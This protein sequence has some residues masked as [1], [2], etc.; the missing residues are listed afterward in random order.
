M[1]EHPHSLSENTHSPEESPQ[2]SAISSARSAAIL[3]TVVRQAV[4]STGM[5]AL[6]T[7]AALPVGIVS[8]IVTVQ[9]LTPT[10]FGR[11]GL[12][13]VLASF[14][15]VLYNVGLLHGT[16]LWV[17]GSSGEGGDDLEIEGLERVSVA[18]QKSAMGAG[19]ILTVIV[20]SCGTAIC[21]LFA[22]PLAATLLGSSR[23]AN[24]VGLAALSGG[25]GSIYRLTCNIFRFERRYTTY[26]L[27]TVARP[28]LVLVGS[29]GLV[30]AGYGIWGAVIGTTIPTL[31]CAAG[32]ILAAHRSYAFRLA[33]EDVRQIIR[34]GATVVIPVVALFGLHNGDLYLLAH[35]V[36]GSRLGVYRLA[37]RLGSPPSYFASAFV[38]TWG[39]LERSSLVTA[40]VDIAGRAKLRA[41]VL[42][43]YILAGLSIVVLFVLFSGLFVL[44]A[45]R[46]YADAAKV[47]PLIA[48]AFVMYGLYLMLLRTARPER[49]LIWY[50]TTAV[51]SAIVFV[52][53]AF[54]LIPALGIDGAPL[55]LV[56]GMSAGCAVVL[57]LNTRKEDPTPI[58]YRRILAGVATAAAVSA[59]ALAGS[60]EGRIVAA[61]C[62]LIGLVLYVPGLVL[63]RAIP[64]GDLRVL[65][66]MVSRRGMREPVHIS[67]D[68]LPLAERQA[69]AQFWA[70]TLEGTDNTLDY[71]RLTRALRRMARIGQP[72]ALDGPIGAYLASREPESARDYQMEDLISQ[73]VDAYE[74]YR[75]DRLAKMLRRR[76]LRHKP[77]TPRS[78]R[79]GVRS[80]LRELEE[81]ER[82]ALAEAVAQARA[83]NRRG[84]ARTGAALGSVR[85]IRLLRE[86]LGLG[87][88]SA[89][90]LAIARALWEMQQLDGVGAPQPPELRALRSAVKLASRRG[91]RRS[92]RR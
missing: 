86:R 7:S 40:A 66:T 6:A 10:Q 72:T 13:M 47:V 16:F 42:T 64:P 36:H 75:L 26:A 22:K 61:L 56:V 34:R 73:G 49:M 11:L 18:S 85:T 30:V 3:S 25:A 69:L 89:A 84:R 71:V 32:C 45:P 19:L 67:P 81:H 12:L 53:S 38:M 82:L 37:S 60:G 20:V 39:P 4:G 91:A 44:V 8:T 2:A 51:L 55:S 27:A 23:R 57:W 62:T 65:L 28:L 41:G 29:T 21:F 14:L 46:S 68:Q 5:Y 31:I 76:R 15:T 48:L 88:P 1:S 35:W 79:S 78:S 50:G 87:S 58:E 59:I 77:I 80:R 9:Y 70:G 92:G 52:G 17:Y 33:A 74:L 24:L 90:D 43:Y 83:A 63:T 54:V